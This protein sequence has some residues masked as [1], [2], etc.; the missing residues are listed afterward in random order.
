MKMKVHYSPEA[1]KDLTSVWKG[2]YDV[3]KS[4]DIAEQYTDDLMDIIDKKRYPP[5]L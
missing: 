5:Q 3:S 2:V 4:F 1:G